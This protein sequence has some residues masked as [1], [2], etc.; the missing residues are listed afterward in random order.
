MNNNLI[1][2]SKFAP[3][4]VMFLLEKE[5]HNIKTSNIRY[6]MAEL[7]RLFVSMN[8]D[9]LCIDETI[10]KAWA[11][12][13]YND[14]PETLRRK[15]MVL[16]NFCKYMCIQGH[17]CYVPR[18]PR[19]HLTGF[20][21]TIYTEKQI[22]DIFMSCDNMVLKHRFTKSAVFML[23]ALIRLLYSTGLRISETLSIKNKDVDFDRN[24]IVLNHTKN[25]LQRL[26]PINASLKMVLLQYVSYRNRIPVKNI[27]APM[28]YF[29]VTLQGRKCSRETIL[30]H[31]HNILS[32]SGIPRWSHQQGPR[33]HDI[34]H[35]CAVHSLIRCIREKEDLYNF[36]PYLS[37]FLGHKNILSTERYVRLSQEIYPDII[38]M[39]AEEI[40]ELYNRI[41]NQI[42][43]IYENSND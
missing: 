29:F 40:T 20:T 8:V 18:I 2:K 10:I 19:K 5:G 3:Y 28:S 27:S 32:I 38:N 4:I 43:T 12:T 16:A 25:N 21:P 14:T 31:F 39:N 6:V 37:T 15:Y 33:L 42:I 30:N 26:V 23:P 9:S 41:T 35:T 11:A 36:L 1:F 22:N 13:R 34:R 7:D 17:E 24:V